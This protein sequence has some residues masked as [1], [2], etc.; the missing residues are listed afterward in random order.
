MVT[1]R[2]IA[3]PAGGAAI[4]RGDGRRDPARAALAAL[5]AFLASTTG[6]CRYAR[7]PSSPGDASAT[8][9]VAAFVTASEPAVHGAEPGPSDTG[10]ITA[11]HAP[12]ASDGA[13]GPRGG[14]RLLPSLA[15]G[16]AA[17]EPVEASR[18]T[19]RP[20]AAPQ[21]VGAADAGAEAADGSERPADP[22]SVVEPASPAGRAALLAQA[23]GYGRRARGGA[24]GPTRRVTTLADDGPG[25]LRALAEDPSGP[26][27]IVFDVDGAIRLQRPIR[28]APDTTIDGRGRRVELTG[29]G[30][31]LRGVGRVVVVNLVLRH[32]DD[33]AVVVRE[34][35][36]DVWLHHLTLQA[37]TDGLVDVQRGGTDVTVSWCHF[38][39]HE[40]VML[41]GADAAHEQDRDLRV[42]LHHNLFERTG[43]RHP[44][45]RLGRAHAFNNVLWHWQSY[46]M[47]AD[48]DG[49]LLVEANVFDPGPDAEE[50]V[51]VEAAD[52]IPGRVR[53]VGN[54]VLGH[55]PLAENDPEAVF[56]PRAD[57]PYEVEPAG[58]GLV[59]RVRAG[60]GWRP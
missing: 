15:A 46:G 44:R 45:L 17:G 22:G 53:A 23:V 35:A 26:R 43:Q 20:G 30:L 34:G 58:E 32:G 36:H 18:R 16:A 54:V 31:D 9:A 33:D 10:P 13:S 2:R 3:T 50:A 21:A 56:D 19:V 60:A 49:Q 7:P 1:S 48:H 6:A 57:Y 11:A 14:R 47:A 27:W 29:R 25:S 28:V 5:V 8:A 12:G 59:E 24:D 38:L 40:K 39:D 42:T 37:W 55:V 4:G 41:L 51:K 52:G